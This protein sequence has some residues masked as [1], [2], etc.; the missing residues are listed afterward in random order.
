MTQTS[1]IRAA[2]LRVNLGA[3][4]L[5]TTDQVVQDISDSVISV[6][7]DRD[8]T[9]SVHGTAKIRLVRELNWESQRIRPHVTLT[10]E[11]SG[12]T[13]RWDLGIY[14][15]ETPR[16]NVQQQPQT[17]TVEA[18]DKLTLLN[19]PIGFT[20]RVAA[21]DFYLTAAAQLLDG[22]QTGYVID[23]TAAAKALPTERIWEIDQSNTYLKVINELLQAVNYEPL[24]ANRQGTYIARA[25]Q[26]PRNR[27]PIFAYSTEAADSIILSGGLTEETDLWAVPNKWVFVLDDPDPA[28]TIP[29]EGAGIYT[30]VNQTD[31]ATSVTSRGWTKTKVARLDVADHL[32]LVAEGDRIVAEDKQPTTEVPLST[33]INP[34]HWHR[35]VVT[36]TAPQIGMVGQRFVER[37]WSLAL[38]DGS[39]RH[40]LQRAA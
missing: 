24:H 38:P 7:V 8:A 1:V 12:E 18:Y 15:P 31:G 22:F 3:E 30:V 28:G 39:M 37:S 13:H 21:G 9:A 40:V 29:L 32:S 27:A 25:W 26:P 35:D 23:Q 10:D 6:I 11:T 20:Y 5:D 34:L 36:V 19:T 14:L 17:Y 4:L 2:A 16:R 33:Q